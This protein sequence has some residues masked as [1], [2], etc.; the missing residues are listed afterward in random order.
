VHLESEIRD[1]EEIAVGFGESVDGNDGG[2]RRVHES[3]SDI[4]QYDS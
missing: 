4:G 3:N 2:I 1:G